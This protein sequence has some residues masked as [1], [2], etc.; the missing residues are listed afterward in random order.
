MV[1]D[2]D[3]RSISTYPSESPALWRAQV[4]LMTI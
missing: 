2:A 4:Q 1:L 3:L